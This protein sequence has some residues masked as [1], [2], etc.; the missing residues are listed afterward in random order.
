MKPI[1][2]LVN[3]DEVIRMLALEGKMSPAEIA[4]RTGL[5]RP[6]VYRLLEGLSGIG[7]TEP[8]KRATVGLSLRWLHLAGRA[9]ESLEEWNGVEEVLSRL[10][11][12]TGQTAFLSVLRG[13]EA[14][15]IE[16]VQGRGIG[17]LM[18]RP[19]GS[20]PLHAGAAGRVLLAFAADS[21]AYLASAPFRSFTSRT[22]TSVDALQR[23]I[24]T[25]R[26]DGYVVSE[27]DV[28]DGISALGVPVRGA[29]GAVIGA[30]SLAGLSGDIAESREAYLAALLGEAKGF[31]PTP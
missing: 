22:L 30:V 28:T 4:E 27:N 15:C 19:G 2:A 18:L 10:V 25:T 9:R 5:P 3:A 11:E 23:D 14:V 20:L 13:D 1:K 6:S 7:F 12:R 16:W 26:S 8:V 21:E 29:D 31:R 17:V 24:E